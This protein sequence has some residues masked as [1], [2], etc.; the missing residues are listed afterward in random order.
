MSTR[1]ITYCY[2]VNLQ[3]RHSWIVQQLMLEHLSPLISIISFVFLYLVL[4]MQVGGYYFDV[5]TV[6][7]L[8]NNRISNNTQNTIQTAT[9]TTHMHNNSNTHLQQQQTQYNTMQS[10]KH[11][12][13][14]TA[15]IN[16]MQHTRTTTIHSTRYNAT[17]NTI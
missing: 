2:V 13:I 10:N 5:V 16:T 11:S 12:T 8:C 1:Y 15:S 7:F 17:Y 9:T 3:F 6:V 14:Q 4:A